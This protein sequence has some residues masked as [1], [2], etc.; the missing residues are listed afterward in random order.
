L[1]FGIIE[2]MIGT[3]F[4]LRAFGASPE[5]PFTAAIYAITGPL[6]APF[7]VWLGPPQLSQSSFEPHCA[8]G[9]IAY[10]LLGWVLAK[11]IG[12]IAESR[13]QA[14]LEPVTL[15][16]AAEPEVDHDLAA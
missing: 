9:I 6:L 2:V 13:R 8:V 10:A 3:R 14:V 1:V 7:S 11:L 15:R 12:L 4:L 5:A 16:R